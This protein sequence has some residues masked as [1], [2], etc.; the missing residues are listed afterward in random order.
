M[1]MQS[2]RLLTFSKRSLF[3]EDFLG[4]SIFVQKQ[5]AAERELLGG[6]IDVAELRRSIVA[7]VQPLIASKTSKLESKLVIMGSIP[8]AAKERSP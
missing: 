6:Q 2:T 3:T 5:I 7:Q 4:V 8:I 1:A